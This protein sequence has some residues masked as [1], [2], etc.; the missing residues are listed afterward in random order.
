MIK[1]F[2]LFLICS[3]PCFLKAQTPAVSKAPVQEYGK[4]SQEDLELKS[5]DFEKDANAEALFEKS[6]VYFGSDILSITQQVHKRIKIFNDNGKGEADIH[7]KY[8]SGNHL[9]YISGLQ[10]ETINITD[11]KTEITK[12]DKKQIYT[13]VIDKQWSEIT[14]AMPNIKPG[15]IIEYKYNLNANSFSDFPDWYFQEKIPVRYS[16]FTT[17][18]PDVFYFRAIPHITVTLSKHTTSSNGRSLVDNSGSYPYNE[19]VETRAMTNLPSLP[20][21][22]MMTSYIDNLQSI[23]FQLVSLRPIGGFSKSYSDTWAKV[24]GNLADDDDFGG[25]LKRKINGEE[26]I[27]SKAKTLKTDEE[28]I[29]YIFDEVKHSM[30]WNGNNDWYTIDGTYRAWENKTGN[31]AEINLILYHLL[32]QSGIK[33][34]PMVTSTRDHGRVNPYY[35]SLSQ[36]N[37]AVVYIPIDSTKRYILDASGK[38][39]MYNEIPENLLNSSGLYIDKASNTYNIVYLHRDQPVRQVVLITADI[40]ADGKM[41][42]TAQLSSFGYYRM[43]AVKK[44]KTDG[45]KKYID[46]LCDHDNTLKISSIKFDNME[47][48]TL[49]LTQ[50]ICFNVDLPG[51]DENYIYFNSNIFTALHN[52]PFLSENRFTDIDFG[53]LSIYSINGLYTIPAGY[54]IDALPK[55]VSMST[56]DKSIVFK[57]MIASEDSKI[58]IR[59]TIDYKKAI[60]FK[61]DYPDFHE[62]FKKM[63]EML[64]EQVVLKKS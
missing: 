14:F 37:Q 48:D 56:P 45:E 62:F 22:A 53:Y 29:A 63:H 59:Y 41:T 26:V 58:V 35:T 15:C 42:G 9:E 64:N 16:E 33:A 46:G 3:I 24:G 61:E 54:K 49:P 36:F 32:K 34:Y 31:S 27:I 23:R 8:Y 7:L 55:N 38:Y 4:V 5:C 50:N 47:I 18:I 30:K 19:E 40:K 43:D 52:N 11:G 57:R 12:L 10:A 60:Y 20:D 2:T 17:S 6:S 13:R 51:A 28:K 39:N 1:P 25:Q 44:Y 21:E